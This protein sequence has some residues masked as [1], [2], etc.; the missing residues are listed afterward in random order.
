MDC[1]GDDNKDWKGLIKTLS[2]ENKGLHSLPHTASTTVR[3]AD[4]EPAFRPSAH[5]EAGWLVQ[6]VRQKYRPP[7]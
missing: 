7:P 2:Y 1:L 4:H 3:E 6:E 5:E